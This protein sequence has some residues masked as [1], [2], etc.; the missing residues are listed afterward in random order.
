MC[1][2]NYRC[3]EVLRRLGQ[4]YRPSNP[5]IANEAGLV[6]PTQPT[7]YLSEAIGKLG[8]TNRIEASRLARQKGWL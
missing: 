7:G 2:G 5:D 4:L 8:A 1:W 6:K 3:C